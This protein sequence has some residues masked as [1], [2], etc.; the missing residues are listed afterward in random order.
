MLST[1]SEQDIG[2]K[3]ENGVD[4]AKQ[5]KDTAEYLPLSNRGYDIYTDNIHTISYKYSKKWGTIG[6]ED[7]I[8]LSIEEVRCLH[9]RPGVRKACSNQ[10]LAV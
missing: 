10:I 9:S 4:R 8:I 1:Y 6:V 5:R 3:G 2:E 7:C